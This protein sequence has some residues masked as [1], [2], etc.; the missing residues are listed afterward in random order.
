MK[1]KKKKAIIGEKEI[2][3]AYQTL[4][5]YKQAKKMLEE[6]IVEEEMFWKQKQWEVLNAKTKKTTP[7]SAWIVNCIINKHADA[8]DSYPEPHVAP[9]A[10]D[11]EQSAETITKI[12]PVVLE[13]ND[14]EETYSDN[15]WYKLKHGTACYGVFWDNSENGGLG[16]VSIRNID[17]LNVFWEPGITNIQKSE[18]IFILSLINTDVLKEKYPD[19]KF[20]NEGEASGEIKKYIHDDNISAKGKTLVVDWYYKKNIGGKN[21]LHFCK[22]AD[23]QLLYS[24]ENE[25]AETGW[26]T[27]GEYPIEF[28]NLYPLEGTP[29]GFGIVALTKNPQLYIDKLDNAIMDYAMVAARPRMVVRKDS[30]INADDIADVEKQIIEASG[31]LS[32]AKFRQLRLEPMNAFVMNFRENKITELKEVSSNRDFAQGGTM[33][34]VTSGAAIA[35]LQEA[36]N[37]TSRDMIKAAYRC[38]QRLIR[39]VI[40]RMRQFYTEERVFRINGTDGTT[41]PSFS[42]KTILPQKTGEISGEEMFR[43]PIFDITISA[44]KHTPYNTL[45]QNETAMNLYNAGFLNPDNANMALAAL[46]MME[47][48]GKEKIIEH[49]KQGQTYQK[50]ILEMQSQIEQMQMER[51]MFSTGPEQIPEQMQTMQP[52]M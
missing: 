37:K 16:D 48:D 29:V 36:G 13:R 20:T 42:N 12:L 34:G 32:E 22:M 26:Y 6:R 43:V 31:D 10:K 49:V 46:E 33:G 45:S 8:M 47:F 39:K 18:N 17:L 25:N 2:H 1:D 24:S 52:A 14:F 21:V 5:E 40:E 50:I 7:S 38:Y 27:D 19:L 23:E 41:Y 30:G 51:G 3:N 11:D 28:D 4:H 44:Q 35:T 15:W 9:R